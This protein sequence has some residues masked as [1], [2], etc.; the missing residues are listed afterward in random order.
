MISSKLELVKPQDLWKTSKDPDPVA[1]INE[2][3]KSNEVG[4]L[5]AVVQLCGKQFKVT[6]GDVIL[7]EGSWEPTNGDKLRLDKVMIKF[8]TLCN[9]LYFLF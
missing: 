9:F 7:V 5:F 3:L 2:Q 4:R 1:R 6:A 8:T